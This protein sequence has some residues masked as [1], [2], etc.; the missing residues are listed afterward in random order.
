MSE[1]EAAP[2]I[3]I[4]GVGNILLRDEGFGVAAVDYLKEAY[5]KSWNLILLHP[6]RFRITWSRLRT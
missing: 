6:A 4:L 3:L 5:R 1:T 2:R